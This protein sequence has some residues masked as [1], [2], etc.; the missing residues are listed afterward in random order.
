MEVGS[1]VRITTA[2]VPVF[3]IV[4]IDGNTAMIETVELPD[5]APG[6]YRW[7]TEITHL[8]PTADD[9]AD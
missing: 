6:K 2:G 9:A 3:R 8:V 5:G 7:P 1:L 4:E